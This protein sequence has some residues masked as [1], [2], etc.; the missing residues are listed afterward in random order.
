MRI[1][2][3]VFVIAG[4]GYLAWDVGLTLQNG[5]QLGTWL[6]GLFALALI[7]QGYALF[8]MKK[9]ARWSGFASAAIVACSSAFFASVFVFPGFPETLYTMPSDV[10]PMFG[11][12]VAVAVAFAAAALLIAFSSRAP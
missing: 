5:I 3:T 4:L 7:Y 2:A 1:A 8:R 10:L 9:G 12:F 11:A 6:M